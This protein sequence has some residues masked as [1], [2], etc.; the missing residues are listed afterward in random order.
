MTTKRQKAAVH[1]CEQWLNVSFNGDIENR[2]QVSA[3]LQEY[4]EDAKLLYEEL[5]CEYETYMMELYD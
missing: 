2:N 1:F 4:L 5:A 3:F